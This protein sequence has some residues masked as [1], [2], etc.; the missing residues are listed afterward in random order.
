MRHVECD[1]VIPLGDDNG[2]ISVISTAV[3]EALMVGAGLFRA[4]VPLRFGFN[5]T[6]ASSASKLPVQ[7]DASK[8]KTNTTVRG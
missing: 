3:L 2:D 5:G 6:L 8:P 7:G 4:A 1:N